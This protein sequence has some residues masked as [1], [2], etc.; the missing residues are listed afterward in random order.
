MMLH[1]IA[2]SIA[3]GDPGPSRPEIAAHH[4]ERTLTSVKCK[5]VFA[6]IIILHTPAPNQQ[7][8]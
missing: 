2:T 4:H 5:T 8:V 7:P 6:L 1:F 3:T